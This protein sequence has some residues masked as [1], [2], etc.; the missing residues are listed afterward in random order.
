[1][2]ERRFRMGRGRMRVLI[3]VFQRFP[4]AFC[5]SLICTCS[6]V[7]NDLHTIC[8]S[9]VSGPSFEVW[10]DTT[11]IV[12]LTAYKTIYMNTI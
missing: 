3:C 9:G 6:V 7:C 5:W 12:I 8:T 4:S 2:D 11:N 1:M 10:F